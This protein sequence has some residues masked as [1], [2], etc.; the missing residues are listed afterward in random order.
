MAVNED[1]LN[2][3]LDQLSLFGEIQTKRKFG[4]VGLFRNGMM[5]GKIGGDT[6]RLKVDEHNKKEYEE[7][8]N[9]ALCFQKQKKGMSYWEVLVEILEDIKVLNQWATKSYEAAVR[10]KK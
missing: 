10:G 8:R 3:V 6:F 4:G 2:L 1:Y 7:K 9:E 5:F